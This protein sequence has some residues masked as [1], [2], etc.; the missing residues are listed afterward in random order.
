MTIPHPPWLKTMLFVTVSFWLPES[1]MPAPT[2]EAPASPDSG[3]LG[4]LLSWTRLSRM[5]VQEFSGSSGHAP[6]CGGGASSLLS[7]LGTM[8][9]R[10][11]SHSEDSRIRWP[12][13][14][15]PEKPRAL[16]WAWASVRTTRQ[17]VHAPT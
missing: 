4:L 15:V 13:A 11:W 1:S 9:A 2:G 3:V 8:P 7:E 12:P 6:F 10:L 16:F 17:S 5:I 14:F